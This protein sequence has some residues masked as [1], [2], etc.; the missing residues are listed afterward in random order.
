ML[1]TSE[2]V[3]AASSTTLR[4]LV[5]AG[6]FDD[7]LPRPFQQQQGPSGPPH[8]QQDLQYPEGQ[9][10][11]VVL[12]M[13]II[14]GVYYVRLCVLCACQEFIVHAGCS[15]GELLRR[16]EDEEI[17]RTD[18]EPARL[19]DVGVGNW[20]IW[21]Y[22]LNYLPDRKYLSMGKVMEIDKVEDILK[23][24]WFRVVTNEFNVEG[25]FRCY[26]HG[27]HRESVPI[28]SVVY[29]FDDNFTLNRDGSI[30][31]RHRQRLL[32]YQFG[33]T[34]DLSCP[35]EPPSDNVRVRKRHRKMVIE[36]EEEDSN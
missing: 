23:V 14:S 1:K 4:Q 32:S 16:A 29:I 34:H 27:S 35:P 30:P 19:E 8:Q 21:E 20:L 22:T 9:V 5:S 18:R 36:D 33:K 7:I 2:E 10:R 12:F 24:K 6:R 17:R 15:R 3:T 13:M 26:T 31:V 11:G 25:R 28:S